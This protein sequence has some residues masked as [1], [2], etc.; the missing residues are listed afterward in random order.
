VLREDLGEGE[1][2]QPVALDRSVRFSGQL[3]QGVAACD[4]RV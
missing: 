3:A 2:A 1:H 4:F